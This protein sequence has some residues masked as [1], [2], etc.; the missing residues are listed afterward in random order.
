MKSIPKST[1]Q[2]RFA[3]DITELIGGTP[4]VRLNKLF[5]G[6]RNVVL[7]KLEQFNPCGSV[8]DR[9]ALSMIEDAE[10]KGRLKPGGTVIEATSGN[11]GIALAFIA[12]VKGYPL[13]VVM[14]ESMSAERRRLLAAF[15][16]RIELSPAHLGM[17]GA[18]ELAM[19]IHAEIKGSFV[20]GQF[21]N[22]SNAAIHETTT[23][24][25]IL[26]DT[27]GKV[28]LLVAGVGTGGTI[29]GVARRLKRHN[30]AI[31]IVAAEP[32]G[33]AVLSGRLCGPHMIQGIGA[34]FVPS[35]VDKALIDE[36]ITVTD[37]EALGWTRDLI[38]KEGILAGISSGAA[39]CAAYKYL[40]NRNVIDATVVVI[41][42]DTGERYLSLPMFLT[43][44]P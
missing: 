27:D 1:N 38:R 18:I 4:L 8:K 42:P 32:T 15:G 12:A 43:G 5:A 20:V 39:A 14:P 41:F 40:K 44:C 10:Q 2:M 17:K 26:L 22:P 16:A 36:V 31:R 3:N 23:A 21:D 34:G 25:E 30:S 13:I 6:N 37:D 35:I 11:T 9:A 33:S 28:D 24:Q 29:T 7:A 19:K